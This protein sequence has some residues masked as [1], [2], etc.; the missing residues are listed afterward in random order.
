MDELLKVAEVAERLKL[1]QQT[2]RREL[3]AVRLGRRRVRVRQSAL[4]AF[5]AAGEMPAAEDDRH[6]ERTEEAA[7]ARALLGAGLANST[8]AL[9]DADDDALAS[10]LVELAD[11]ARNLAE[12]LRAGTEGARQGA[13]GSVR[14]GERQS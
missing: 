14:V 2:V 4:D 1:N 10:A 13:S 3:S 11:A 5:V 8:A 9:A 12:S 6:L 7:E